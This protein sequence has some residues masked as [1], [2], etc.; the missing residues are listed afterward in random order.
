M[1]RCIYVA[2]HGTLV[3]KET[4]L[5]VPAPCVNGGRLLLVDHLRC[6]FIEGHKRAPNQR[7]LIR[8]VRNMLRS[9]TRSCHDA[10]N[11]NEAGCAT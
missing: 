6:P 1:W 7:A 10:Q 8:F 5:V 2:R 11:G 4:E 9:D 3:F